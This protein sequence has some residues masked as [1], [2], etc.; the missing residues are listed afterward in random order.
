MAKCEICLKEFDKNSEEKL[1]LIALK[2][3]VAMKHMETKGAM[4]LAKA[5]SEVAPEKVVPV[6]AP[7]APVVESAHPGPTTFFSPRAKGLV[8]TVRPTEWKLVQTPTG[9]RQVP[10]EGKYA[11]FDGGYYSTDDAEIIEYL[12][13]KYNHSRYPIIPCETR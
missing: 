10:V 11:E 4:A 7:T 12:K 5:V 13:T 8:V 9:D 2:K 6:V 3:H 1:N